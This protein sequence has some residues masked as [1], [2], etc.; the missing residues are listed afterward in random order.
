MGSTFSLNE[1]RGDRERDGECN[2]DGGAEIGGVNGV[3]VPDLGV[4][5]A[6]F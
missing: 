1:R 2:C 6:L 5:G 3:T 4:R